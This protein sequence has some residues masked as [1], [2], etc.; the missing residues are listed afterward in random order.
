MFD[1]LKVHCVL[2]T[3]REARINLGNILW[4]CAGGEGKRMRADVQ[5]RATYLR[6][7]NA[8]AHSLD[9]SPVAVGSH[10]SHFLFLC[11]FH[12]AV[13]QMS[14]LKR[15]NW[16]K[17]ETDPAE[18]VR[19]RDKVVRTLPQCLD[20]DGDSQAGRQWAKD[21]RIML[22]FIADIYFLECIF[23]T[24]S[25]CVSQVGLGPLIFLPLSP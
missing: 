6:T 15:T 12:Q 11:V 2:R 10:W 5:F 4:V 22:I 8:R 23:R 21:Y 14:I 18:E 1:D 17:G 25:L 24:V 3:F 13:T 7:L 16:W 9:L 20:R 19:D